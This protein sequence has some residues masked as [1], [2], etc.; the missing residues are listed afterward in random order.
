MSSGI[1]IP[2]LS[3][4]ADINVT[5]QIKYITNILIKIHFCADIWSTIKYEHFKLIRKGYFSRCDNWTQLNRLFYFSPLILKYLRFCLIN[6]YNKRKILFFCYDIHQIRV[7]TYCF[8]L[9]SYASLSC[10]IFK[11]SLTWDFV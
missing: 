4:L 7:W 10:K 3:S 6:V 5:F 2:A 1:F 8:T 9:I 11:L